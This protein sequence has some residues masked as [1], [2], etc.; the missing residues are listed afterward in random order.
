MILP[1][2]ERKILKYIFF[3]RTS[4]NMKIRSLDTMGITKLSIV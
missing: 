3:A 4:N 1:W 2:A